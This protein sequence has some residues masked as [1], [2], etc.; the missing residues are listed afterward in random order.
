MKMNPK[1][2]SK[3]EIVGKIVLTLGVVLALAAPA[4][5]ANLNVTTT[6]DGPS[7]NAGA[8][9]GSAG[10][11]TLVGT[12]NTVSKVLTW[13]ITWSGLTGTPTLMHFHGPAATN[14]N[15]VV[16]E[17]VGV[18]GPP[19]VGTATLDASQ[20]ADLIAGLWYLNLHTTTSP[21]GEIRGQVSTAAAVPGPGL[22]LVLPLA[23]LG[24]FASR[25]RK[26]HA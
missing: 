13:N 25:T 11:G 15:A 7:A 17:N 4:G 3:F 2:H 6:M 16:Q 19:V 21:G 5:A 18:A 8:G 24:A 22:A 10:T 14:Q 26:R 12:F 20:E 1:T 9:T 23:A